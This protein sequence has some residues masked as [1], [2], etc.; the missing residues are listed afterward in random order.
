MV[1]QD[2][3]AARAA[4]GAGATILT[5]PQGAQQTASRAGK[6]LTGQ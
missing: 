2:T 6:A 5:G 3:A 1:A 4:R